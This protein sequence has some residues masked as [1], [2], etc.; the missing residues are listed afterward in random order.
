MRQGSAG[1]KRRQL[2]ASERHQHGR[3]DR[4]DEGGRCHL[5]ATHY[6][7]PRKSTTMERMFTNY[8]YGPGIRGSIGLLIAAVSFLPGIATAIAPANS[9]VEAIV[10]TPAVQLTSLPD[11]AQIQP[12]LD[13]RR[14]IYVGEYHTR[15]EDHR[16]QLEIIRYLATRG[17]PLAIGVEWFQQPY[18]NALDRYLAGKIDVRELL[19]ATEY[20]DRWG[21]DFRLY[22]PIL[23]YARAHGIPVIALN[24]PDELSRAAARQ[25]LNQLSPD[26]RKWVP[27]TID[28]SDTAYRRRLKRIFSSHP[29]QHDKVDFDHFYTVQLLWDEGMAKRAAE[30]LSTHPGTR[31][32]ILAGSGH[33]AYG[34]GIPQRLRRRTGISGAIILPGW[35]G[36]L[37]AGL[38]DY[39]LLPTPEQLPEPGRLGLALI[40]KAGHVIVHSFTDPSPARAAGVKADDVVLAINGQTIASIS[41][42]RVALWD[43]QPGDVM[44]LRVHRSTRSGENRPLTFVIPLR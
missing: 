12:H 25:S 3:N 40:S 20:Y 16:I 35:E 19:R 34:S 6:R 32:V 27:G 24:I 33:L 10:H 17:A 31:M 7:N 21:Y 8:L 38:A 4:Q 43:H 23:R 13:H 5:P 18:Q 15:P 44:R 22:A 30:Y 29:Q 26:L 14:V 1:R 28:R 2:P 41:D 11:L 39:L 37:K 9:A 42:V 36:E